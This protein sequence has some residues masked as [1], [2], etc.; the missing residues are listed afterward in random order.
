MGQKKQ[1]TMYE[2][3]G[4]KQNDWRCQGDCT[5][6]ELQKMNMKAGERVAL[7]KQSDKK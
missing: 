7:A 5:P 2:K 4:I 3:H 1:Q 6:Q